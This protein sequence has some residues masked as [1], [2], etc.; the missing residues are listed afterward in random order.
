MQFKAFAKD[1][2]REL[3]GRWEHDNNV[4]NHPVVQVTWH[5][6]FAY[7]EWLTE[8][9]KDCG[10]RV[11]LPTEGQWEKA[12][13]GTDERAYPWGNEDIDPNKANY[14]ETGISSTSPVGCFPYDSTPYG[15]ID[16]AGNVWEWC[17]DWYVKDYYSRSPSRDPL[18]PSKGSDRV[19]RGGAWVIVARN[20]R[21]AIRYGDVPVKRNAYLGF[22][23]VLLPGQQG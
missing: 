23:L 10:R 9:L 15:I 21:S 2:G 18:G 19:I 16:M 17:Q 14:F 11:A 12:A 20:C 6:A 13:R 5:D 8:K 3:G 7:C 4:D 22:R 1:T